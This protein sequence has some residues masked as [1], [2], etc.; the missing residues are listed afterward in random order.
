M[1]VDHYAI[2]QRQRTLLRICW[3]REHL[4]SR[5]KATTRQM[6]RRVSIGRMQT[7]YSW[8]SSKPIEFLSSG[9]DLFM[10][11][12]EFSQNLKS[13]SG[14]LWSCVPWKAPPPIISNGSNLRKHGHGKCVAS[15]SGREN[16]IVLRC[17]LGERSPQ[18]C[19]RSSLSSLR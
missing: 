3:S 9:I 7:L 17:K 10:A 5:T 11:M 15:V 1:V 13:I 14:P 12:L 4:S 2:F 16:L 19:F 6:L 18:V 8:T